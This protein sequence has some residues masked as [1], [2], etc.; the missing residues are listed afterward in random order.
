MHTCINGPGI[1]V[2][3]TQ[4]ITRASLTGFLLSKLVF[5]VALVRDSINFSAFLPV[6]I[7][8][9]CA[10]L[11]SK[12][13]TSSLI[14]LGVGVLVLLSRWKEKDKKKAL[15][16]LGRLAEKIIISASPPLPIAG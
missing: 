11:I 1:H 7:F 15:A 16:L 10:W 6:F 4:L 14:L 8:I 3:C 13:T 5:F 12:R 9:I 2:S